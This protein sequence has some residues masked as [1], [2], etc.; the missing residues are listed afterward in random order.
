MVDN[1]ILLILFLALLVLMVMILICRTKIQQVEKERQEAQQKIS[2]AKTEFLSQISNDIKTPM[3]VIVGMT[4]LG[5]E[6]TDNP[7]KMAECLEK[8]D[9]ASRFLM[10][11]LNDLVDM[12]KIEMGRFR[13]HPRAYAFRDFMSSIQVMMEQACAE[14]QI[15]FQRTD[16]DINLNLWVDSMRFGQI[17]FN[18]LNN[19]VK[20]TPQG[21]VVS[22]H[23]CNYATHNNHF[24]AD[25][26]VKDTGIGMS[27][28]FQKLLFEPFTQ[29]KRGVAH[30]SHGAG[31]GLAIVRN[32][33]DLMDGTIDIKSEV[34]E[35]TEV[36]VHLEIELAEIQPETAAGRL[37]SSESHKIL[38]GKRVLLVEDHPLNIEISRKI[39]EHQEMEVECAE[40]GSMAVEMFKEHEAY[41]FD[42]ILMDILMPEMD[43]LEAARCIRRVPRGDAQIIP[44]IAMSVNS[45]QE[46]VDACKEA[47]MNAYLAKPIEPQT[48][49]Q[50]LCEYLQNPV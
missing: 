44:I 25:Y 22:F 48:L 38:K 15:I 41:Y 9:T 1:A 47:G 18:L 13:L 6:E 23:I 24:S 3:N 20:F 16:E 12:S 34:G 8:I 33:V 40:T 49:Y 43:G 28:E 27:E 37:E 19:A 14:K 29:E 4:A 10:E 45:A 39:L 26:V 46:N 36:K 11:L 31:L 35:G 50:E 7:E 21:G 30:K 5:M 42:V 32:I 17:F 2:E